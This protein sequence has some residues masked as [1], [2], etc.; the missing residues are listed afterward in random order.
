MIS[1]RS[2]T[3]MGRVAVLEDNKPYLRR[4]NNYFGQRNY[5]VVSDHAYSSFIEHL[6]ELEWSAGLFII[7]M[8]LGR[9]EPRKG[10]QVIKAIKAHNP[11]AYVVLHT[12]KSQTLPKGLAT[13]ADLL[14]NK[15]DMERD[16]EL[17]SNCYFRY[18]AGLGVSRTVSIDSDGE[19][20]YEVGKMDGID[21]EK[22]MNRKAYAELS[23]SPAWIE[24]HKGKYVAIVNGC[25]VGESEDRDLLVTNVAKGTDGSILVKKVGEADAVSLLTPFFHHIE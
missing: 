17:I 22:R 14:V 15:T 19:I 6:I 5:D 20:E 23:M 8:H 7:D 25:V 12:G 21:E 13:N 10:L 9:S 16:M 2:V 4:V 11:I 18:I 1:H 24:A 3:N